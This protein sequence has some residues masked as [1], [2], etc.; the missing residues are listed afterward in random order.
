MLNVAVHSTLCRSCDTTK[1]IGKCFNSYFFPAMFIRIHVCGVDITNRTHRYKY[2][3]TSEGNIIDD[4]KYIEVET[5]FQFD[6]F[7]MF[8]T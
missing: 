1:N 7:R 2:G 4:N 8:L 6:I 3:Y 5:I